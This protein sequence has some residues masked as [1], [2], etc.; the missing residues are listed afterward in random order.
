VQDLIK[1]RLG[2]THLAYYILE[3]SY[4]RLLH[5]AYELETR[6]NNQENGPPRKKQRREKKGGSQFFEAILLLPV[7]VPCK[8]VF[9]LYPRIQ[10]H[11]SG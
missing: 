11:E 8:V 7:P 2:F 1:G 9:V 4:R 3:Y 10:K 5:N 6:T